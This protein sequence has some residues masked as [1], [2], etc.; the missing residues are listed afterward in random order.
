MPMRTRSSLARRRPLL[1]GEVA[2]EADR[3]EQR[4][5]RAAEAQHV[6]VALVLDDAATVRLHV[7][8]HELVVMLEHFEPRRVAERD[9]ELASTPR[10]R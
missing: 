5:A 1:A 2:L 4:A 7:R 9:G 3:G 10:C 8:G 6:A